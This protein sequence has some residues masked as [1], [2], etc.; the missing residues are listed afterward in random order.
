MECGG[1][2]VMEALIPWMLLWCA[3]SCA[4][5]KKV[6]TLLMQKLHNLHPIAWPLEGTPSTSTTGYENLEFC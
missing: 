4:S 6:R 3:G 5:S 2:S 1:L